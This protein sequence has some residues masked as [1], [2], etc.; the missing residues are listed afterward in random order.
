MSAALADLPTPAAILF[1][2]DGTLV[3]TVE[4]RIQAWLAAFA[5]QGISAAR[6]HV[7]ALIGSDGRRL[8][9]EVADAAG[10]ELGRGRDE[11]I[12]ARAGEL[13]QV[14]NDDPRPLPGARELLESLDRS[15]VLWAIA[16]SSRRAQVANSVAALKLQRDPTIVD[17]S[18]VANAKPAPDLL[19]QAARQ[20]DVEPSESWY[21]GDSTWD[22][23]AAVAAEM[24]PIGVTQGAAVDADALRAAGARVTVQG[25]RELLTRL[26][27]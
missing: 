4:T 24:I 26:S 7:A 13:Y 2:L 11:V 16:T 1:D 12:D 9:R 18:A 20:L 6:D 25:L 8:A 23:R 27:G 14:L 3:D 17:G 15:G 22:M 10:V 21:V 19:L 5:E